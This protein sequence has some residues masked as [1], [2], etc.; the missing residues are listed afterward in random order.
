MYLVHGLKT[1]SI[2]KRVAKEQDSL[3]MIEDVFQTFNCITKTEEKT[4][5]YS[6]PNFEPMPRVSKEM[7]HKV[8]FGIY[9]KPSPTV[10]TY[11]SN[12]QCNT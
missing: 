4:K 5:A 1:P 10:K 2:R 12:S 11:N 8:S 3:R 9:T 6:E 7:V